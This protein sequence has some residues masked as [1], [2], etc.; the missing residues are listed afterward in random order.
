MGP[1]EPSLPR[2]RRRWPRI[3]AFLFLAFVIWEATAYWRGALMAH[4]DDALGQPELRI[5][6]YPALR[7]GSPVAKLLEQR[8]GIRLHLEGCW[9]FNPF[10]DLYIDGYNREM[11]SLLL[12]RH[13][14][15]CSRNARAV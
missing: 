2:K 8:Y 11:A 4:I 14:R 13:G 12:R 10:F 6:G 3:L 9:T 7:H 5:L 1:Q 15:M